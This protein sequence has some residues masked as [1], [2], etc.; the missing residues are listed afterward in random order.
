[1]TGRRGY[2]LDKV[3]AP[4]GSLKPGGVADGAIVVVIWAAFGYLIGYLPGLLLAIPLVDHVS[5][6]AWDGNTNSGWTI[7]VAGGIWPA[8][9]AVYQVV[10]AAR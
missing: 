10:R 8:G 9:A 5:P 2:Y 6:L 7:F 4:L 1:M 3:L